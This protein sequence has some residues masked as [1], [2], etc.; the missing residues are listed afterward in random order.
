MPENPIIVLANYHQFESNGSVKQPCVE[1]RMFLFCESGKG[2]ICANGQWFDV[3]Q[4]DFFLLPWRHTL[5]YQADKHVPFLV[6]GIHV[7]P[8]ALENEN[9]HFYNV[10][11]SNKNPIYDVAWRKDS[12]MENLSEVY[13][14]KLSKAPSLFHL[15]QYIIEV[16]IRQ[17]P[18]EILMRNLGKLFIEEWKSTT[19]GSAKTAEYGRRELDTMV[20]FIERNLTRIID[21][22]EL[23]QVANISPSTVIRLF[24][25]HLSLTPVQYINQFRINQ[26]Q[27]ILSRTNQPISTV[28]R[29][30]GIEDQFYF[31]KL[32]KTHTGSSPLAY[33]KRY[34][35]L[36]NNKGLAQKH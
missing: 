5:L 21:L 31:S 22:N 2:K 10:A 18:E 24:K 26:A 13:A 9:L 19:K 33:R 8:N 29:Q 23:A 36:S 28:A 27:K 32:F 20:I 12:F 7:I 1:S 6:G 3:Q 34:S 14:G 35:I 30:V 4:D 25:K 16:F 15:S 17:P 11:H